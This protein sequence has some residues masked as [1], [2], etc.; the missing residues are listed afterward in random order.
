M[1]YTNMY[2]YKDDKNQGGIEISSGGVT[3]YNTVQLWK[4]DIVNNVHTDV[5]PHE[6]VELSTTHALCLEV[7]SRDI[8]SSS[9]HSTVP[10]AQ[11]AAR[12]L[13]GYRSEWQC[14]YI[15]LLWIYKKEAW[16]LHCRSKD[17]F[18]DSWKNVSSMHACMH[19]EGSWQLF[20]TVSTCL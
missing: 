19:A 2:V 11:F 6:A 15:L 8:T 18:N 5:E 12:Y 14:G 10:M 17:S 20:H 9:T 3:L 1:H 13:P 7:K 4:Y 16:K